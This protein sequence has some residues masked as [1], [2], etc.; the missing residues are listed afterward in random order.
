MSIRIITDSTADMTGEFRE[1]MIQVPL[2]VSFGEEE[3]IDGVTIDKELFYRKLENCDSLPKTSQPSPAAFQKVYE[4]ISEAGDQ[5]IV[6]TVT[7]K[8]SGTYQCACVA[9]EDYPNIRVVDSLSASVGTGILALYALRCADEGMSLEKLA[10]HL[11]EKRK[12]ICVIARVETLQYLEKGGRI[13]KATAL[14]GGI[15]N[16]KPVITLEDGEIAMLG[17]ARGT[18]KANNILTEQIHK[19]GIDYTMPLLLGYSGNSDKLLGEYIEASRSLWEG[20]VAQLDCTQLC[21]VIGTYAGPGAVAVAFFIN[22]G[23]D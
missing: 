9:A 18:K 20:H 15:L 17:K 11:E 22:K 8:L 12:E 4:E 14:A 19:A 6:I 13:S 16:I 21:S 5:G 7:S 1:K 10:G 2:T 23:D 3:Y